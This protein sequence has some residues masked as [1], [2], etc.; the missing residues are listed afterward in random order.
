ML[1]GFTFQVSPLSLLPHLLVAFVCSVPHY[2]S[3]R[4]NL[5]LPALHRAE[6]VELAEYIS[7]WEGLEK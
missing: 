4:V 3:V 6:D 1:S 7:D 2:K 5:S